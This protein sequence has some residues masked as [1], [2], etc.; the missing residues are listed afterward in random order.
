M[1]SVL[2]EA[3]GKLRELSGEANTRGAECGLG[4]RGPE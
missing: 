3:L 2:E 1:G 4:R